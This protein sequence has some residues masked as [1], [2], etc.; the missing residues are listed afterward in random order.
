VNSDDL[1]NDIMKNSFPQ[2]MYFTPDINNDAHDTDIMF[3]GEWL[4]LFLD[5]RYKSLPPRIVIVVTWDEDDYIGTNQIFTILLGDIVKP[6]SQD[7]LHYT[8]FSILK[9][10][11]ENWDLGNLGRGDV[12][13]N[14]FSLK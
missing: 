2:Y 13:A 3:A 5:K 4:S 8:H 10:V 12:N 1:D 11:E 6:G 7:N 9:S 14:P